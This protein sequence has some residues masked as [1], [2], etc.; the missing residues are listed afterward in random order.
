MLTKYCHKL[1]L[2][3]IFYRSIFGFYIFQIVG[4]DELNWHPTFWRLT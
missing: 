3:P 1:T 2:V 4:F